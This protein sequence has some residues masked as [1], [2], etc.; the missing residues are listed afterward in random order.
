M[1]KDGSN[2]NDNDN[3]NSSNNALRRRGGS[4]AETETEGDV[5]GLF[6]GIHQRGV[7]S[8]GGAVHGGSIV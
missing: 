8:E 2:N 3:N 5:V 1:I 4:P 7:Q 6:M